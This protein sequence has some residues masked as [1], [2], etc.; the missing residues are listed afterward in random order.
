MVFSSRKLVGEAG[1]TLLLPCTASKK[2]KGAEAP[3]KPA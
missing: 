3:L 2:E 1:L